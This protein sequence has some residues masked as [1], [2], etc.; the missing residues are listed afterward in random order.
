MLNGLFLMLHR[1]VDGIVGEKNIFKQ[2][3]EKEP[4]P[5]SVSTIVH[6]RDCNFYPFSLSLL[7]TIPFSLL[8]GL[9][10]FD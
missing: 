3:R 2:R 9:Y 8:T 6:L 10:A 7:A 1:L 5:G 4:E